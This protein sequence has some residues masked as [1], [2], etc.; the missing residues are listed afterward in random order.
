MPTAFYGTDP[1]ARQNLVDQVRAACLDK[2]FFQIINHAVPSSLQDKMFALAH[3]F[4]SL[5]I[6]EKVKVDAS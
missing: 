5:P 1:I 6:E 4:F 2:G 3:E